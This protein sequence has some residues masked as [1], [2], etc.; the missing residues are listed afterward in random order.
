MLLPLLLKPPFAAW[1]AN[2]CLHF[3]PSLNLFSCVLF[4]LLLALS[5]A[6]SFFLSHSVVVV[7]AGEARGEAVRFGIKI[8]K[9]ISPQ[10]G[11]FPSL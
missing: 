4:G 5:F 2:F 1:S 3:R 8:S 11:G 6:Y 9:D 7:C 10:H